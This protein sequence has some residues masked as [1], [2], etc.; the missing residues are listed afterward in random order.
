MFDQVAKGALL[1]VWG[2]MSRSQR[3]A[4]HKHTQQ[5][6]SGVKA[7]SIRAGFY[8]YWHIQICDFTGAHLIST[9]GLGEVE[10]CLPLSAQDA[11]RDTNDTAGS[12]SLCLRIAFSLDCGHWFAA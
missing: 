10:S 2:L 3:G 8:N 9:V 7:K 6:C 11:D 4:L 12:K 1:V 5:T